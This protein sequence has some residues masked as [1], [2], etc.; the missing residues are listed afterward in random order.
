[1]ERSLCDL[2][3]RVQSVHDI[4]RLQCISRIPVIAGDSFEINSDILVR[5]NQ[6][7]RPLASD[8]KADVFAFFNPYRYTYGQTWIDAIE[9]GPRSN[10][11]FPTLTPSDTQDWLMA[12]DTFPKHV[13]S[14][15]IRIYN[16]YFRDPSF[17]ELD[18]DTPLTDD[19][20]NY[21][22]RVGHLKS[23]G[24][25]QAHLPDLADSMYDLDVSG[26]EIS[27]FDIQSAQSNAR[28]DLYRDFYSSRYTEIMGDLA[29]APIHDYAD[30]RPE[31]VFRASEWLSG[32]D[33]NGTSG[34]DLGN[35]VGK[36]IGKVNFN[37]PRR[38][39]SE[40]GSLTLWMVLRMPPVFQDTIQY[41]DDFNRGLEHIIPQPGSNFPP[42]EL[43]MNDLFNG[44]SSTNS[45]GY[46]PFYEWY[47]EHP[48]YIHD[49]FD[50]DDT[51]WQFLSR[52]HYTRDLIETYDYDDMFQ[53][54]KLRHAVSVSLHKVTAFRPIPDQNSSIMGATT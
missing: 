16:W 49:R 34:A 36:A 24:T 47:R 52:P 43:F 35:A 27:L 42:Q 15:A 31:L 51:G 7:R 6:L 3:H 21:G 4:G 11:T 39:F 14:D 38:F 41:L 1:M 26:T 8:V 17:D 20:A 50:S 19:G 48:S 23:W 13:L 25:A 10:P 33:V 28:Q 22:I 46:V 45:A 32:F 54:M 30:D 9:Q 37:M 5:L 18:E 40:H 12:R 44:G 53:S 2:T 29:G